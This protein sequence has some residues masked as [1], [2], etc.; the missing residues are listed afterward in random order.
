MAGLV[1]AIGAYKIFLKKDKKG[2]PELVVKNWER[3]VVYIIQV[4]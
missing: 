4:Y 3:G 1:F 2:P